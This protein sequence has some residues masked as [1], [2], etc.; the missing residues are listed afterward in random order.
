MKINLNGNLLPLYSKELC[1]LCGQRG[2]IF[3]TYNL[4]ECFIS[5]IDSCYN[6]CELSK[7]FVCQAKGK[8]ITDNFH[9]A[10]LQW[11]NWAKINP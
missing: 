3:R 5:R 7:C 8:S 4:Q 6:G 2:N 1:F 11:R 9:I 10:K